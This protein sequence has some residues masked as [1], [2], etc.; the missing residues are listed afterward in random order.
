MRSL[1]GA[2]TG[3][4]Q[5]ASA[6]AAAAVP[7]SEHESEAGSEF[8]AVRLRRLRD[9]LHETGV[10]NRL[11]SCVEQMLSG[12]ELP[13]NP[14]PS[15]VRLLRQ[16]ET[17]M[18]LWSKPHA[19]REEL[20][21]AWLTT[22]LQA[23]ALDT[24]LS[25]L[26][27]HCVAWRSLAPL[28]DPEA[29]KTVVGQLA[30][31]P[32]L[33]P[34]TRTEARESGDL[35]L[36]ACTALAG[37]HAFGGRFGTYYPAGVQL[38]EHFQVRGVPSQRDAALRLWESHICE[39]A[40]AV[41]ASQAHFVRLLEVYVADDADDADDEGD[42]LGGGAEPTPAAAN[43]RGLPTRFMVGDLRQRPR[44]LTAA[45]RLAAL[46]QQPAYLHVLVA[47]PVFESKVDAK[48]S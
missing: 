31:T 42:T 20:H 29:I 2:V 11:A 7:P 26:S 43:P 15:L 10:E 9:F 32:L 34:L 33:T 21:A 28:V 13:W 37:A 25:I 47:A 46:R 35:Q 1:E 39:G 5:V 19:A 3:P 45:L 23:S 18:M 40:L 48:V 30:S 6:P 38:R 44:A 14:Y 36:K 8:D 24:H 17:K 4:Q 41:D 12:E 22:G 16:E 27:S